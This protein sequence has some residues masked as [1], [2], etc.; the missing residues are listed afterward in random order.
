M[1][2]N[3]GNQKWRDWYCHFKTDIEE[4][5]VQ[6]QSMEEND[7]MLQL[8]CKTIPK[9]NVSDAFMSYYCWWLDV[10]RSTCHLVYHF[11]WWHFDSFM[12]DSISFSCNDKYLLVYRNEQTNHLIL[13][14]APH[15]Q[16]F[17]LF[18]WHCAFSLRTVSSIGWMVVLHGEFSV[19]IS[20]IFWFSS[21][22]AILLKLTDALASIYQWKC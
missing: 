22:E 21:N 6:K 14:T 3:V 4:N 2:W 12:C 11:S 9:K 13:P 15:S 7:K 1:T 5:F 20:Y 16:Y 8:R 19:W 10:F 17:I 18:G